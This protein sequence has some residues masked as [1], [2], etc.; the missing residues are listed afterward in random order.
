MQYLEK[1]YLKNETAR[2]D[3]GRMLQEI[4]KSIELGKLGL[5]EGLVLDA[6]DAGDNPNAILLEDI[7]PAICVVG[8]K[9]QAKEMP[10]QEAHA[11]AKTMEKGIDVLKPY[12]ASRNN[13]K[14]GQYLFGSAVGNHDIGRNSVTMM[15]KIDGLD[16]FEI[17]VDVTE[18]EFAQEI[19]ANP[20]YRV[21][22]TFP[23][24]AASMDSSHINARVLVTAG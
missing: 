7:I 21:V 22:G 2:G 5:I 4:S 12:L 1:G 8:A 14:Y 20:N 17:G 3:K 9:L 10:L 6:L 11:S 16:G 23:M 13:S 18:E 15:I 19:E 24:A